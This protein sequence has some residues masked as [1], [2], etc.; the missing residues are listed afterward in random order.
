MLS[1]QQLMSNLC[2]ISPS[3]SD[4]FAIAVPSFKSDAVFPHEPMQKCI[5]TL[6]VEHFWMTYFLLIISALWLF[7]E[8]KL[9][10]FPNMMNKTSPHLAFFFP[11]WISEGA[12]TVDVF[13]DVLFKWIFSLVSCAFACF[14]S[15]SLQKTKK[16]QHMMSKT[17]A[18]SH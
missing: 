10:I 12:T 6:T 15:A 7:M 14:W 4:Q 8:M 5:W 13:R 1:T 2:N 17:S 16:Q 18:R 3:P 11:S 9:F